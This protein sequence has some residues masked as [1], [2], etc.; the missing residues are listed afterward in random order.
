MGAS[1]N[2]AT[3]RPGTCWGGLSRRSLLAKGE[4]FACWHST[5]AGPSAFAGPTVDKTA[6]RPAWPS[7]LEQAGRSK[8]AKLRRGCRDA[9]R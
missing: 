7:C 3:S 1:W 4:A 5:F 2:P 9:P 6:D 8:F